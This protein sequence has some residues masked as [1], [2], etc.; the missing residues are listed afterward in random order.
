VN[1]IVIASAVFVAVLAVPARGADLDVPAVF[2]TVGDALAAAVAGDTILLAP[3]VHLVDS[4]IGVDVSIVGTGGSAVTE[5]RGDGAPALRVTGHAVD[6]TGLTL[7]AAAWSGA[8][9]TFDRATVSLTDVAVSDAGFTGDGAV[10]SYDSDLVIV[11]SRFVDNRSFWGSLYVSG[12]SV[13]TTDVTWHGRDDNYTIGLFETNATLT[14]GSFSTGYVAIQTGTSF[15]TVSGVTFEGGVLSSEQEGIRPVVFEDCLFTAP[16]ELDS[17][18]LWGRDITVRRSVFDAIETGGV[19]VFADANLV[20]EDTTFLG[21]RSDRIADVGYDTGLTFR[22]NT[23]S[24]WRGR[25]LIVAT[26]GSDGSTSTPTA[27]ARAIPRPAHRA[28]CAPSPARWRS[29]PTATTATRAWAPQPR[30]SRTSTETASARVRPS[31]P[32]RP[33]AVYRRTATATTPTTPSTP[34]RRRSATVSTRTA[35]ARST[36]ARPSRCTR[37]RTGMGSETTPGRQ[38]AATGSRTT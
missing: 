27:T 2:P 7:T 9:A 21:G 15:V 32:A 8:V 13:E 29:A 11:G 33:A 31:S 12:G 24:G 1:G 28:T 37:T 19:Y 3:G 16:S 5:L 26:P 17:V 38:K 22:G 20:V 4:R 36:T 14:G 25:T 6:V 35:T 23:V 10:E 30:C 34:A 18:L